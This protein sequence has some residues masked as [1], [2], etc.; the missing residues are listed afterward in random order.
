MSYEKLIEK[1]EWY[2][3]R[4]DIREEHT[5]HWIANENLFQKFPLECIAIV[6]PLFL[7]SL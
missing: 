2:T 6:R 1:N 4:Y 3:I 7:Y 5:A